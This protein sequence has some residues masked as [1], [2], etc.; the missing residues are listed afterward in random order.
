MED[1]KK[2]TKKT[3]AKSMS[4]FLKDTK[5]ILDKANIVYWL[6]W[7]TLLGAIRDKKVIEWDGDIDISTFSKNWEN[8]N[9]VLS[10]FEKKGFEII[11]ISKVKLD[12]KIYY[13]KIF[14]SRSGFHLDLWFYQLKNENFLYPMMNT[15][16]FIAKSL[17]ALNYLFSDKFLMRSAPP[18]WRIARKI[19]PCLFFLSSKLK[20]SM[21]CRI[22]KILK[23]FYQL[24]LVIVPAHYFENLER[25]KLYG[26]EFNIPSNSEDYLKC[27]Y[28]KNWRI[29]NKNFNKE[30]MIDYEDVL[31]IH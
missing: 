22:I 21:S 19:K 3:E 9:S 18:L 20:K 24:N 12:R 13:Q 23:R 28:G 14:L 11:D 4:Q 7:G 10:E 5:E 8:V 27:K 31:R 25:I 30:G 29:P 15:T 17:N 2:K 6:D 1:T 26:M 16:N